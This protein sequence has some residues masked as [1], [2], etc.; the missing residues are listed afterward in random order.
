MYIFYKA[1]SQILC[2]FE[3]TKIIR[4]LF[5]K[6]AKPINTQKP[7][8]ERR[9]A[10]PI[11]KLQIFE[12]TQCENVSKNQ[13]FSSFRLIQARLFFN[14]NQIYSHENQIII[15]ISFKFFPFFM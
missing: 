4:N 1:L 2:E 12:K 10:K 11:R 13:R 15:S 5:F 9:F 6:G 14:L 3:F 8:D 7:K